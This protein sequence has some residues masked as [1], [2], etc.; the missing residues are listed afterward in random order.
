[1]T[2]DER[3]T[4]WRGWQRAAL[5]SL[6]VCGASLAFLLAFAST[7]W[8]WRMPDFAPTRLWLAVL[9]TIVALAAVPLLFRFS[10]RKGR[11][12]RMVDGGVTA[13][14]VLGVAA[15]LYFAPDTNPAVGVGARVPLLLTASVLL[16]VAGG[17]SMAAS[18]LD[19]APPLA[20]GPLLART[21]VPLAL[22]LVMVLGVLPLW[23]AYA[24][25]TNEYVS[26]SRSPVA[27]IAWSELTGQ[28]AWSSRSN[29]YNSDGF[30]NAVSTPY[31][32]ATTRTI[33]SVEMLDPATGELR[34]RYSRSDSDGLPDLTVTGDGRFLLVS[35][36]DVGYLLLDA[37]TGE[38]KAAWPG[39]TQD[40]DVLSADPL[41]TGEAVGKGSDKLRGVDADG[42]DR[43]T[44]EPGRC[45]S[46]TAVATADTALASFHRSCGK[47]PDELTA[48]DLRS[49]R[50]LWSRAEKWSA[51]PVVAGGLVVGL[52]TDRELVGMEARTGDVKWRWQLPAALSCET[53][54]FEADQKVVLLNCPAG[55]DKTQTVVTVI[56][57][58]TGVVGWQ[59]T[60][61]IDTSAKPAVTTDG[62]VV[63]FVDLPAG[64]RLNVVE[65]TGYRAA[66]VPDEV[67]C[68]LGLRAVGNVVLARG[69]D[70]LIALR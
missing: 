56:D 1:M 5:A 33:G 14:G 62:R 49:G 46:I 8:P 70:S 27:P 22:V 13:A 26:D 19:P 18:A 57:A 12:A 29:G 15:V 40:H 61:P 2:D 38:R 30:R 52:R 63:S 53:K 65:E 21:A 59:R 6:A 36:D 16:V 11:T 66:P 55:T 50:K 58:T 3:S 51:S 10:R 68:P 69:K 20:R 64:C 34:W 4:P 67:R 17:S 48:L 45:T 9:L 7:Q 25:T 42:N 32:V 35:F 28:V 60:A 41:L 23:R 37:D 31:G 43:W 39:R 44:F 24:L 47:D 54:L